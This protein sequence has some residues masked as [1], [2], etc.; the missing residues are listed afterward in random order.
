MLRKK[1]SFKCGES[2]GYLRPQQGSR[3]ATQ[4]SMQFHTACSQPEQGYSLA[5][6]TQIAGART[7]VT[8]KLVRLP[9]R[10]QLGFQHAASAGAV[11][12]WSPIDNDHSAASANA[13]A[14]P[15]WI[16]MPPESWRRPCT[17][18]L[19]Q[20]ITA[21]FS[22]FAG[23]FGHSLHDLLPLAAW[24]RHSRPDHTLLMPA[25]S[26]LSAILS[27]ID[28]SY[29]FRQVV[30]LEEANMLCAAS[31]TVV[32]VPPSAKRKDALNFAWIRKASFM[33][34]LRSSWLMTAGAINRIGNGTVIVYIRHG[35]RTVSHG[36]TMTRRHIDE[37]VTMTKSAMLQFGI[38]GSLVRYDG[39]I[40]GRPMP[41]AAQAKLFRHADSVVGP[42][43]A[44]L[45][46]V[47]W[48]PA[49]T[50]M[51][52]NGCDRPQVLEFVC[53]ERSA[54][55]QDGCPYQRSHWRMLS[56]APWV[57]WRHQFFT[58]KSSSSVTWVDLHELKA[59]LKSMWSQRRRR[60]RC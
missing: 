26:V 35:T 2:Q 48:L 59:S 44:G 49:R 39:T 19:L 37:I 42:H 18:V 27:Y 54:K 25:S 20:P 56:T 10:V 5:V 55:V 40:N 29:L 13:S 53:G 60:F 46:N 36:R 15:S 11:G 4:R 31:A 23:N 30:L 51:H 38:S 16:L 34:A 24:L 57:Q 1:R 43:G 41:V 6:R 14:S 21:C 58:D 47:L 28:G 52:F 50:S 12:I 22:F 9:G 45:A 33:S 8:P 7:P 17:R 3:T 32:A